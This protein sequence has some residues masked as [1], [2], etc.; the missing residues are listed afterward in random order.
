MYTVYSINCWLHYT[1][2]NSLPLP[3]SFS[4]LGRPCCT[5]IFTFQKLPINQLIEHQI[6]SHVHPKQSAQNWPP[7]STS[8]ISVC[9][10]LQVDL[11][12]RLIISSKYVF[13]LPQSQPPSVSPH[14]HIDGIH[15]YTITPSKCK[16]KLARLR[17]QSVSPRILVHDLHRSLQFLMIVSSK[18]ADSLSPHPIWN[19]L[20]HCLGVYLFT[21]PDAAC[22]CITK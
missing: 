6:P 15:V 16:T 3:P 8:P 1:K 18:L 9:N 11:Q 13:I 21:H 20:N 2:I 10:S 17:L 14:L 5:E 22:I 19:P 12:T 4:S 7:P